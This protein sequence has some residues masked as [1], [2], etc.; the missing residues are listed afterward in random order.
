MIVAFYAGGNGPNGFRR[1]HLQRLLPMYFFY[2]YFILRWSAPED[3]YTWWII[4]TRDRK[5]RVRFNQRF[6]F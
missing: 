3:V 4:T 1:F 2:F 6:H 5:S